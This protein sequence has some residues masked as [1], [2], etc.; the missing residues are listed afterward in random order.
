MGPWAAV[1]NWAYIDSTD[2]VKISLEEQLLLHSL[3][4]SLFLFLPPHTPWPSV[5]FLG[6][7]FKAWEGG[8]KGRTITLKRRWARPL[9]VELTGRDL[10]LSWA[11]SWA[12]T[13]REHTLRWGN[14]MKNGLFNR[15]FT[16]TQYALLY[17]DYI[18]HA[19]YTHQAIQQYPFFKRWL[20]SAI[21]LEPQTLVTQLSVFGTHYQL[22]LVSVSP[23]LNLRYD[24]RRAK[25]EII[26]KL[27]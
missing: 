10:K 11:I 4:L 16:C 23:L 14:C 8:W 24:W 9:Q 7:G 3:T 6:E 27:V 19:Y 22:E 21:F 5:A 13:A 2:V 1:Q 12:E 18:L 20:W 26:E 17:M 25:Y 15:C